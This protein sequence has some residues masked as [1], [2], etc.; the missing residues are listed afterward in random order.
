MQ[1]SARGKAAWHSLRSELKEKNC[2][3]Q[4]LTIIFNFAFCILH[5]NGYGGRSMISIAR[6]TLKALLTALI[7]A[8]VLIFILAFIAYRTSDPEKLLGFFGMAAF[9]V[10][11]LAGGISAARDKGGIA[12]SV[13]FVLM[14]ILICLALSLVLGSKA[15]MS[16]LVLIYL[17]GIAAAVL[18]TVLFPGGRSK[19]PKNLKRYKN[20]RS[21]EKR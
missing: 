20:N 12:G 9:F 21:K 11:C 18:G 3:Q 8:A 16:K 4:F 13:I 7:T 6:S 14:Y 1:N 2:F 15:G 19:K 5:Y 17:G 10:S